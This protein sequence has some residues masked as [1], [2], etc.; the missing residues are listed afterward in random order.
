MATSPNEPD[1]TQSDVAHDTGPPIEDTTPV[2]APAE[3]EVPGTRA[4]QAVAI[5]YRIPPRPDVPDP[6]HDGIPA[7]WVDPDGAGPQKGAWRDIRIIIDPKTGRKRKV[8]DLGWADPDDR[9]TPLD[10]ALSEREGG[11]VRAAKYAEAWMAKWR[12]IAAGTLVAT[13]A[14]AFYIVGI[15]NGL[16]GPM[17]ATVIIYECPPEAEAWL[18]RDIEPLLNEADNNNDEYDRGRKALGLED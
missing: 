3:A 4:P 6:D 12:A 16:F 18:E 13:L 5:P 8:A 7:A 15:W 10:K 17:G 1:A 9:P 2:P 14:C 11:L